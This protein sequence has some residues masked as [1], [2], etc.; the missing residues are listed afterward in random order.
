MMLRTV[1]YDVIIIICDVKN[2][3]RRAPPGPRLQLRDKSISAGGT[4]PVEG[5]G[6][7]KFRGTE[8][9]DPSRVKI[10]CFHTYGRIGGAHEVR[11]YLLVRH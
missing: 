3:C 10:V 5:R 11:Q 9:M 7:R 8:E 2:T 4:G 1:R 6:A